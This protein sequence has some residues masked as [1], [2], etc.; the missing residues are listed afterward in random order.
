M[1]RAK[2]WPPKKCRISGHS[3]HLPLR[4]GVRKWPQKSLYQNISIATVV[5]LS[6]PFRCWQVEW[7]VW[8][9]HVWGY[10]LDVSAATRDLQGW[11]YDNSI[12]KIYS[13][14]YGDRFNYWGSKA[15][16]HI[17][18]QL[19]SGI[20]RSRKGSRGCVVHKK[21]QRYCFD[22]GKCGISRICKTG[23]TGDESSG[24]PLHIEQTGETALLCINLALY[25]HGKCICWN[26]SDVRAGTIWVYP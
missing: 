20:K 21:P 8:I 7:A 24:R 25:L 13:R 22:E 12:S 11:D 17:T 16:S 5:G 19:V 2:D 9:T 1:S 15:T 6:G 23:D 18:A 26:G 3:V 10:G 14:C 4:V